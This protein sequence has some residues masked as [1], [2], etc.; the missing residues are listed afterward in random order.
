LHDAPAHCED[1]VNGCSDTVGFRRFCPGP[2]DYNGDGTD[3]SNPYDCL[4][5]TDNCMPQRDYYGAP[6]DM[7]GWNIHM[8]LTWLAFASSLGSSVSAQ[9]VELRW[10]GSPTATCFANNG[11]CPKVW[12]TSPN[13]QAWSC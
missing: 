10:A 1:G 2:H 9:E 11:T 8:V 12:T 7:D 5:I 3:S 13:V 4:C 6:G